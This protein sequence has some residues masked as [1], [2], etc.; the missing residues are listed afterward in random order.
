MS[1]YPDVAITGVRLEADGIAWD[2]PVQFIV[3]LEQK[4]PEGTAGVFHF[5]LEFDS[6]EYD[7]PQRLTERVEYGPLARG[8]YNVAVPSD[9]IPLPLAVFETAGGILCVRGHYMAPGAPIDVLRMCYRVDADDRGRTFALVNVPRFPVL[10]NPADLAPPPEQESEED[11]DII[12]GGGSE[13]EDTGIEGTPPDEENP[14]DEELGEN[15]EEERS[16]EEEE[17]IENEEEEEDEDG[18]MK[19]PRDDDND[20]APEPKRPRFECAN[21]LRNALLRCS[22]CKTTFYCNKDCQAAHYGSH[23]RVCV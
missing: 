8:S 7:A 18:G 9:A 12:M 20:D 22:R 3:G 4:A 1:N 16:G 10:I 5:W 17:Y 19:R 2:T 15:E 13:S 11:S 14:E 21:C 6:P 23:S